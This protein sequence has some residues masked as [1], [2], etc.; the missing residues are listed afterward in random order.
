MFPSDLM[1]QSN[2][3]PYPD[4]PWL[5]EF[6]QIAP[7][8]HVGFRPEP[9]RYIVEGN[10]TIIINE[11]D[12]VVVDGSGSPIASRRVIKHIRELTSKNVSTVILTHHHG[13]H[14]LGLESY[15][16]EFPGVEII[17]NPYTYDALRGGMIEYANGMPDR[18]ESLRTGGFA[19][20][21][22]IKKEARPGFEKIVANLTRYYGHVLDVRSREYASIK[23][24]PS[25]L[26]VSD[27]LILH[28]GNRTIDI[29]FL[30]AGDTP[31]DMIVHLPQDGIVITGDM[32]V[33]PVPY[34]YSRTVLEWADT[35]DRLA[36]LEF[37]RIIPGHGEIKI[38]KTYLNQMRALHRYIQQEVSG[39]LEAGHDLETTL[40]SIDVSD[41]MDLFVGDDPVLR[42]YFEEYFSIPHISQV[43]YALRGAA[44]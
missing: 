30:G 10:V 41:Q 43:F 40:A 11:N 6:K 36:E 17:S 34:G 26:T 39:H 38:G 2:T 27:R 44:D 12:V 9:L 8:I 1:A 21:E 37:E 14:V 7:D 15:V 25:T 18:L 20:I 5:I 28:R 31:G 3:D 23:V 19:E 4:D 42:Y 16:D 13:D 29:R 32:L 24:T 33:D 22:R 35:L